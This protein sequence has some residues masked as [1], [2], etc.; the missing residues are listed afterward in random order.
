MP[1]QK[2]QLN[3]KES[4]NVGNE[5]QKSFKTYFTPLKKRQKEVLPDTVITLN[6][7]EFNSPVRRQ[8][9]SI[10]EWIKNKT[11]SNCMLSTYL[12]TLVE[13]GRMGKDSPCR[14]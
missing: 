11:V 8:S 1:V 14:Q 6:V 10:T 3:T 7:D 5:G 9:H 13:S 2:S 4:S 12:H